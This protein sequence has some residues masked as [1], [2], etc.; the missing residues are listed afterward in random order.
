M[1]ERTDGSAC[2]HLLFGLCWRGERCECSSV[3]FVRPHWHQAFQTDPN[4][5]WRRVLQDT[6]ATLQL[7]FRPLKR[8]SC[9]RLTV[10][11]HCILPGNFTCTLVSSKYLHAN[12]VGYQSTWLLHKVTQPAISAL[13]TRYLLTDMF[14]DQP[15]PAPAHH[16]R[17]EFNNAKPTCLSV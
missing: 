1:Q 8:F 14:F 7:H 16:C 11:L 4:M 15:A 2:R 12:I 17:C 3:A 9:I 5:G 13:Q 10:L 6:T